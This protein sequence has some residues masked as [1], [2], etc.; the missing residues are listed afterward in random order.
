[1]W[2]PVRERAERI[3]V[4]ELGFPAVD[5]ELLALCDDLGLLVGHLTHTA[6][7]YTD[8]IELRRRRRPMN[9]AA[10][11]QWDLL[12]PLSFSS[13]ELAI[14]G[15]LEPAYFV[16]GDAFDYSLNGDM[17][18]FAIIDAMGHGVHSTLAST[19]ALGAFRYGRRRGLDLDGHRRAH[20]RRGGRALPGDSFVTGHLARL[21][22]ATGDL[23][24]INAGHPPPLLIRGAK[25]VSRAGRAS[26]ASRSAWASTSPRSASAGCSRATGCCSTPTAPSRPGPRPGEQFGL[27]RLIAEVEQYIG[28]G[29]LAVGDA[30]PAGRPP[31]PAP[32]RRAGGRR[33]PGVPGVAA[34]PLSARCRSV[35]R[36]ASCRR[37]V[38]LR[39]R[40]RGSGSAARRP[41]ISSCLTRCTTVPASGRD[42]KRTP[43][44][45]ADRRA[46]PR[47]CSAEPGAMPLASD[48]RVE[49]AA[50]VDHADL[51]D[52][53]GDDQ[54]HL[55][56]VVDAGVLHHVGARL[57]EG[58]GHV[59]DGRR[60]RR[61]ARRGRTWRCGGRRAGWRSPGGGRSPCRSSPATAR[62]SGTVCPL[63]SVGGRWVAVHGAGA[64]LRSIGAR[65]PPYPERQPPHTR[66]ARTGLPE[67]QEE[68]SPKAPL[69][70][71]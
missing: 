4:L 36:V 14:A 8:L 47:P 17:L 66:G 51:A 55:V 50:G 46:R 19:L 45:S 27:D 35:G 34:R 37:C 20:R 18:G 63:R 7:R 62:G 64:G 54:V 41:S 15:L 58:E 30:A 68:R 61:P 12:P 33:H 26:R 3:G 67:R 5:D 1:M 65:Y 11:M 40:S 24:W 53:V 59:V 56:L 48:R 6:G 71:R 23:R 43:S 38:V 25:V 60:G 9:L 16:A 49:P 42:S 10:E 39:R 29:V 69:L 28:A 57:G 31:P 21:D 13:P 70:L 32:G 22:V 44:T 52:V 2:A